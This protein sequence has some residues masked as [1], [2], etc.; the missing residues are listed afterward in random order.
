MSNMS[1]L[2]NIVLCWVQLNYTKTNCS[3]DKLLLNF[4][5]PFHPCNY[6]YIKFLEYAILYNYNVYIKVKNV[7]GLHS[8][9]ITLSLKYLINQITFSLFNITTKYK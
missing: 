4:C 2:L 7:C 1:L 5:S 9:R 8:F 6:K 3:T